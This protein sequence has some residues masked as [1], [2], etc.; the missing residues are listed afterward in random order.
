LAA[1]QFDFQIDPF[2]ESVAMASSEIV[3]DAFA[4][5]ANRLGKR[6]QRFQTA[7][8]HSDQPRLQLSGRGGTVMRR[9]E[10]SAKSFFQCV[11]LF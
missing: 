2:G 3:E 8:G 11:A 1:E 7:G 4:P 10:P 5:I 9:I 6:L